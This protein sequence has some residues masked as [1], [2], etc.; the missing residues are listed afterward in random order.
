[1]G[2]RATKDTAESVTMKEGQLRLRE[3]EGIEGGREGRRKGGREGW[4]AT[5]RQ[6]RGKRRRHRRRGR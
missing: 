6:E 2:W 1:M 3:K 5:C 4:E